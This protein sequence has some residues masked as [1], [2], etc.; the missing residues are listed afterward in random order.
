M[1]ITILILLSLL[2]STIAC[3]QSSFNGKVIDAKTRQPL[4]RASIKVKAQGIEFGTDARGEFGVE[5]NGAPSDTVEISHIGYKTKKIPISGFTNNHIV[6]LEDYSLQLR[7]VTVTSRKLNLKSIDRSIHQVKDN[8]YA[9]ETEATNGLYNLF[10]KFLQEEDQV[11]LLRLCDYDLSTYDEEMKNFYRQYT[12]DYKEPPNKRDTLIKNYSDYPAVNIRHEAVILFCQWFTEQYN[13][14]PGK[15]RF[16]E[17]KFRLPTLKEWQIAALGNPKFQ[18][19]DLDKNTLEVVIPEDT[20]AEFQ[21]GKKSI[22]P[23]ND[24]ILYPWW[25]AY[26]YRS[27]P[28]NIKKCYLGNFKVVSDPQPCAAQVVAYDGWT[29]MAQTSTY[30]PN[31][32]GLYDVVGNVAEMIDEKGKA[33]GGSWDD[34]PNESTIRSVEH[35][36]KPSDSI[37]FRIFMEVV[38]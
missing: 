29:K 23:V 32:M 27:K 28:K 19:W 6:L 18:S 33:L 26:N 8:L 1:N 31:G 25:A 30:F 9:Y 7:T 11:E 5:F 16:K 17:V 3:A 4:S 13:Y 20:I 36:D 2:V 37:G 22:I 38:E 14:H 15:K 24:E 35:F 10:L 21:K 34:T 12:A